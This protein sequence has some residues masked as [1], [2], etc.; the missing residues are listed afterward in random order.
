M[1]T[2]NEGIFEDLPNTSFQNSNDELDYQA[3]QGLLCHESRGIF[4]IKTQLII[5]KWMP[6]TEL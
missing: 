6:K 2:M 1:T 3:K 5:E 4:E